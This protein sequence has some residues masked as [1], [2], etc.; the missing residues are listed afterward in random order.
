[1]CRNICFALNINPYFPKAPSPKAMQF[2]M[3]NNHKS[4]NTGQIS[5]RGCRHGKEDFNV[6]RKRFQKENQK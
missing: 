6:E 1:L 2:P 5:S 4:K 3:A